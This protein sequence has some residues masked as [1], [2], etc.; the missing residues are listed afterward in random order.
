MIDMATLGWIPGGLA[1]LFSLYAVFVTI[2]AAGKLEG[3]L[4][5]SVLLLMYALMAFLAMGIT[6]GVYSIFGINQENVWWLL[7][8]SWALLGGVLYLVGAKK[9]F[10]VL[11]KVSKK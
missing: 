3:E 1:V 10:E 9:L 6:L 4:K 11:I 8:P 5:N 2:K 7:L